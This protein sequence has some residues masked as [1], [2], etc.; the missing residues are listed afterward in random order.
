MTTNNERWKPIPGFPDY[1]ISID[2]DIRSY[3][4]SP[5]HDWP[6]MLQPRLN[7]SGYRIVSL[8]NANGKFITKKVSTLVLFAFEGPRPRGMYVCHNDDVR[9][10]DALSNL[11]YDTPA[12]NILD[13][14]MRGKMSELT[15]QDI[16]D[17][18]QRR[19]NGETYKSIAKDYPVKRGGIGFICRG[20]THKHIPVTME[21]E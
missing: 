18:R 1:E 13:A 17:I 2:G 11:R 14:R 6:T 10:N 9:T 8:R 5:N 21:T 7:P 15:P 4:R 3:R 16:V 12:A 20:E 19:K